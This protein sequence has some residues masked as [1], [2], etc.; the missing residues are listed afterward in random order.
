MKSKSKC[1]DT[2]SKSSDENDEKKKTNNNDN[3]N[4]EVV[5]PIASFLQYNA[6]QMSLN[7]MNMN[8]MNNPNNNYSSNMTYLSS[9][10]S[11]SGHTSHNDYSTI[12]SYSVGTVTTGTT[13]SSRSL[14]GLRHVN[15]DNA[16]FRTNDL[17]SYNNAAAAFHTTNSSAL[18]DIDE[19]DD[20]LMALDNATALLQQQEECDQMVVNGITFVTPKASNVK[21]S[22]SNVVPS[23]PLLLPANKYDTKP[24][25]HHHTHTSEALFR[26]EEEESIRPWYAVEDPYYE[27]DFEKLEALF[28]IPVSNFALNSALLPMN[29]RLNRLTHKRPLDTDVV[30]EEEE[31]EEEVVSE[32]EEEI[33]EPVKKEAAAAERKAEPTGI[34]FRKLQQQ[35]EQPSSSS[36]S[37]L[38]ALN[39]NN[40][41]STS[42]AAHNNANPPPRH[43]RTSTPPLHPSFFDRQQQMIRRELDQTGTVVEY[44]DWSFDLDDD[45]HVHDDDGG[46][47]RCNH[48][49]RSSTSNGHLHRVPDDSNSSRTKSVH[50]EY[51]YHDDCDDASS[52]S[53]TSSFPDDE[54]RGKYVYNRD[55]TM[56]RRQEE[57]ERL[58]ELWNFAATEIQ[59]V[60]RG[61]RCRYQL[62]LSLGVAKRRKWEPRTKT[63]EQ[64]IRHSNIRRQARSY[65]RKRTHIMSSMIIAIRR[66]CAIKIQRFLKS[67]QFRQIVSRRIALKEKLKAKLSDPM[68]QYQSAA[69]TIQKVWRG[70]YYKDMYYIKLLHVIQI[71]ACVRGFVSRRRQQL[72]LQDERYEQAFRLYRFSALV[73]QCAAR[74]FLAKKKVKFQRKLMLSLNATNSDRLKSMSSSPYYSPSLISQR[75][76][77]VNTTTT[78]TPHLLLNPFDDSHDQHST[79]ESSS[80]ATATLSHNFYS[81]RENSGIPHSIVTSESSRTTTVAMHDVDHDADARSQF[82]PSSSLH[83]DQSVSQD[84]NASFI[85]YSST[86]TSLASC[87]HS[88]F[89]QARRLKHSGSACNGANIVSPDKGSSKVSL[90]SELLD[91]AWDDLGTGFGNIVSFHDEELEFLT[92]E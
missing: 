74:V 53:S 59:R 85:S 48:E 44:Q 7:N 13:Q 5:V 14:L 36:S 87:L 92:V 70:M 61:R 49:S 8:N 79:T 39:N 73:I 17:S 66:V 62:V 83:D 76:S 82:T 35:Q 68:Y 12:M 33:M 34:L 42:T 15:N 32:E 56:K 69:I 91:H 64:T 88:S 58:K 67:V 11:S 72:A 24:I 52:T 50:K 26:D 18:G 60:I 37:D 54:M 25:H 55:I 57:E 31:D 27:G 10:A 29:H 38:S 75:S 4:G 71:Q 9:D 77:A 6:K 51:N 78:S 2:D 46:G 86:I 84:C 40:T 63:P 43:R 22:N 3:D 23:Q 28:A 80:Q 19:D 20:S 21:T 45:I 47:G 16:S 81:M 90:N 65:L 30:E 89:Q 1:N 41:T